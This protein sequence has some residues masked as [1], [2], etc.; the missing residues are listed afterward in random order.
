VNVSLGGVV[1]NTHVEASKR[2]EALEEAHAALTCIPQTRQRILW[3][4]DPQN[5][6][7]FCAALQRYM[8]AGGTQSAFCKAMG[9]A[10]Y[11]MSHLR[12]GRTPD[13]KSLQPPT[14]DAPAAV[15][16]A[17]ALV[18]AMRDRVRAAS[19]K[20]VDWGR[21]PVEL[22]TIG[23]AWLR[24]GLALSTFARAIGLDPTALKLHFRTVQGDGAREALRDAEERISVLEARLADAERRVAEV[25]P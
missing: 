9:V 19:L 8:D 15:R 2:A 5:A 3:Q 1:R 13:G 10:A 16:E 12:H 4:A 17:A 18:A 21:Y 6:R 22:T 24:S 20:R 11:I 25:R 23:R 14:S 7:A